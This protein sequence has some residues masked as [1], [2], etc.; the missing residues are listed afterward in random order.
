[1]S[2]NLIG[3]GTAVPEFGVNQSESIEAAKH[4]CA[5]SD[6]T[7]RI[8]PILYRK[9]GVSKRHSVIFHSD[10]GPAFDRQNLFEPY[11]G[12]WDRGP[13]TGR[14]MEQYGLSAGE[15]A[16]AASRRALT[17]AG[18]EGGEITHLITVSCS[19]F[20]A[21][22]FDLDLIENLG[23]K[24]EVSR[25]HVGFM[26]CHAAMN[27]LRV[28]DAFTQAERSAKVLVCATELCTLH[29]QYG[30]NPDSVLTNA[31]FA[32]GSAA[33]VCTAEGRDSAWKFLRS[34]SILI[35]DS[36][37]AMTW[38]IGDFGFE[39]TLSA[40][41][42]ELIASHLKPWL[43]E[44]LDREGLRIQDVGAWALHPGGPRILQAVGESLSL[45]SGALDASR[46]ILAEFGNM[47][48]PT[49]LFVLQ[50]LKEQ[51]A[52]GPCVALGF[53]P[54]LVAEAMLLK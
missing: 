30:W 9:S 16:S 27:A 21:P 50:R 40:R 33:A 17:S 11:Q 53:G 24:R 5:V 42:P 25:T 12:E 32:D 46:A 6:S 10:E 13:T 3:L 51:G 15:L 54:G 31:L 36:R 43:T 1:M 14:R 44:W 37:E 35:P 20:Q 39:M 8:L 45:P 4:F 28:A 18:M 49:I 7:A 23:L 41:V 47:S 48:S 26:G 2:M 19:G 34:G 22:G 52:T 38:R 29:C